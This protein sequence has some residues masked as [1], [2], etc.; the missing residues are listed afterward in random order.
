MLRRLLA[1]VLVPVVLALGACS[2]SLIPTPYA[3]Y[4]EDGRAA[5]AATPPE[6]RTG[7][8]PV[9]Y[10][11]DRA[12]DKQSPRGPVYGY[13]RARDIAFGE[14]T[15]SLGKDVD[16][17]TLVTD[18]TGP[19]RS[20]SY[21]PTLARVNEV[22]TIRSSMAALVVEDGSL[23]FGENAMAEFQADQAA[24]NN[25]LTTWLDR[26]ERKEVLIFVHGYNNTFSDA[27]LRLAQAW[28]M[29]GRRGVPIVY[30]W[31]A[32][33]GG[34][35][36]YAY[37][38]E[39]GEFTVVHLKR[40]LR[41]VAAHPG[42]EKVHIISHSRGTDVAFTAVR[43][44]HAEIRGALRGTGLAVRAAQ[45]AGQ[46]T[47][48]GDGM[49]HPADTWKALKLATLILAAPDLDL[50]VFVQ[51]FFAEN[52][53]RAAAR[54][55]IYFSDEDEALGLADWLFRSRARLGAM[56]L[57]DFPESSR[58]VLSS[59]RTLELINCRVWGYTSHSYILQHPAALSDLMRVLGDRS[60]PGTPDRPL[61]HP[62]PGLWQLD[63][64]YLKPKPSSASAK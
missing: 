44:L 43:E 5:F 29:G 18:S 56:R 4:G 9:I 59:L 21:V 16:W 32:G 14:A 35:K 64:D 33:S 57:K 40:L 27:V 19:K 60:S 41:I 10:V 38:R 31:P 7:D 62:E 8:I 55:V 22:G 11:T 26:A 34:L 1:I 23:R 51:R 49:L 3:A 24:I 13:K 42:V 53:I 46:Q 63:N 39:S 17:D 36:G 15:V 20:R 25:L 47:S 45:A 54:T 6:L 30:T 37:D 50:D 61:T 12:V 52:T 58:H 48:D 28:H 2:N